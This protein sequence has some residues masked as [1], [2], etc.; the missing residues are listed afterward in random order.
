MKIKSS[1]VI[2]GLGVLILASVAIQNIASSSPV[3]LDASRTA[4]T[5]ALAAST[6]A[7]APSAS[8]EVLVFKVEGMTCGACEQKISRALKTRSGVGRVEVSVARGLVAVESFS[9]AAGVQALAQA[10]T[11]AGFPA[12]FTGKLKAMPNEAGAKS[13]SKGGCGS[14]CC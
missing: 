13:K 8:G 1:Y 6:K 7:P 12:T 4:K 2:L 3:G 11:D 9:K 5:Q 14:G 10:V